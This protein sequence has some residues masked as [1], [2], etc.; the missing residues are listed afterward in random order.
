MIQQQ[1]SRLAAACG[2]IFALGL[3]LA[4]GDG[5]YSTTRE[6]IATLALSLAI[7]FQCHLGRLLRSPDRTST[8]TVD[9]AVA[10]GI[11]GIVLKLASGIPEVAQHQ[12]R[13]TPSSPT[14]D[15]FTGLAAAFTVAS[16]IPLALC[17][18]AT[19]AAILRTR[20]LPRW[21][22]LGAAVTAAALAINGSLIG[23]SFV[24]ALLVFQLWTLLTSLHL[25]RASWRRPTAATAPKTTT[26]ASSGAPSGL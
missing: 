14:Y 9:T 22:G 6:L 23:A 21:V 10:A 24:P 18:A 3:F 15:A 5:G 8:W 11:T 1:P 16:L 2:A 12:A 13:L 26:Q 17:C 4:A 25:L 20:V 7:P 19:A